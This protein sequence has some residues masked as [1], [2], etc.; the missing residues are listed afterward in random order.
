MT[1]S[2]ILFVAKFL[3]KCDS[4]CHK[5]TLQKMDIPREHSPVL[6]SEST[7]NGFVASALSDSLD[8]LS[9]VKNQRYSSN[10]SEEHSAVS[11][12]ITDAEQV[13]ELIVAVIGCCWSSL[14]CSLVSIGN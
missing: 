11:G 7:L 3:H 9:D 5:F 10:L 12:S 14:T 1:W 6:E 4:V 8:T 2:A 13:I